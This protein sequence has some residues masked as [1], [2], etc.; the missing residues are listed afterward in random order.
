MARLCYPRRSVL[1][2]NRKGPRSRGR[3]AGAAGG[4][5]RPEPMSGPLNGGEHA[6]LVSW[7]ISMLQ[8]VAD[9]DSVSQETIRASLGK[10]RHEI[11]THLAVLM[12]E[13]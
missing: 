6:E 9:D 5:K 12:W 13:E 7:V 1:T 8:L 4:P 11:D 2:I 10:I 3:Q